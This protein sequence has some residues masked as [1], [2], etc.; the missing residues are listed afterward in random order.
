MYI[1]STHVN[2]FFLS[3]NYITIYAVTIPTV[4]PRSSRIPLREVRTPL[5]ERDTRYAEAP[6]HREIDRIKNFQRILTAISPIQ[7]LEY[8]Q[9][10]LFTLRARAN[11]H[12][13]LVL[14]LGQEM[15]STVP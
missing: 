8:K 1:G 10:L 11:S 7:L 14:E 12:A 5:D 4:A 13:F 9:S 6:A 15:P 3:I 2:S